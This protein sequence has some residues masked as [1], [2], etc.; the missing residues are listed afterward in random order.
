MST[1]HVQVQRFVPV[2]PNFLRHRTLLA[3]AAPHHVLGQSSWPKLAAESQGPE[4]FYR[5]QMFPSQSGI[6]WTYGFAV[7]NQVWAADFSWRVRSLSLHAGAQEVHLAQLCAAATRLV[8]V[9]GN[10]TLLGAD[11]S[12][13]SDYTRSVISKIEVPNWLH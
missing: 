1:R 6:N 4:R 12:S 13:I 7:N 8:A 10:G 11:G 5:Q 9:D 3:S 2:P